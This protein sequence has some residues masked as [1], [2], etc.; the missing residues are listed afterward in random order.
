MFVTN[1]SW[2]SYAGEG[3]LGHFVQMAGITVHSFLSGAVGLAVA[4]TLIRGLTRARTDRVGNFWCDLVRGVVRV[5]LSLS[6]VFAVVL[7][8]GGVIQNLHGFQS[9]QTLAGHV[10]AVPGGPVASQEAIKLM[11]GDGGGFYNVNSAHP[12][13]NPNGPT[14]I[15]E[16]ILMLLVPS[17]I[18][19]MYG[20][21]VGD[22][23]QGWLL[24]S[25]VAALF[26]ASLGLLSWTEMAHHGTVGQ[27]VAASMEGKETR[28]GPAG[29]ALFATASTASADGAVNGSHDS[30]TALGGGVALVNMLLGEVSPGGVGSGLYGL[31]SLALVAVFLGGLMI[32]RTPEYL[33][34][35][36]RTSEIRLVALITLATP[37]VVLVGT[38]LTLG[39]KTPPHS[40]LNTGAHG[41][42]EGFYAFTSAGNTNGSA[43]AGLSANTDFYNVGLGLAMLVGRYV[44][45][46]LVIALAGSFAGQGCAPVTRGTLPTHTPMFAALTGGVAVL[47]VGLEYLPALAVGPLAEVMT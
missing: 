23:R 25:V 45:M 24:V 17:A 4:L 44:T 3:A 2:Q 43:F 30:L 36:V 39:L 16:I 22:T 1:T 40:F 6:A 10:Q 28:S 37:I 42:S 12:F 19:R 11:S 8:A 21:M 15:V 47:I 20:R 41:L 46:I 26:T 18:P 27:A 35:R 34:K 33:G 5:L 14:N 7:L 38:G 13:E 29:T 32:G 9:V 31:V